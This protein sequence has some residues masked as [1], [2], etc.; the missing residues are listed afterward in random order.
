M[1]SRIHWLLIWTAAAISA[2]CSGG[3]TQDGMA[4]DAA[5]ASASDTIAMDITTDAPPS[6][7]LATDSPVD[8]VAMDTNSMDVVTDASPMDSGLDIID[9]SP[10]DAPPDRVDSGGA[11]NT[12]VPG[13]PV[14]TPMIVSGPPP[15]MTGGTIVPGIY[16]L[17]RRVIYNGGMDAGMAGP[18]QITVD[19]SGTI[20]QEALGMWPVRNA[21][22]SV[23]TGPGSAMSVTIICP[24]TLATTVR[25]YTAT[26]TELQILLAPSTVDTYTRR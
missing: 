15:E 20:W 2:A 14:V 12:M 22:V 16:D 17:T 1:H 19:V 21:T 5:D 7:T 24:V 26:S 25:A 4:G 9:V 3:G 18:P 6:D 8:D 10:T 11:C 23:T 13:G